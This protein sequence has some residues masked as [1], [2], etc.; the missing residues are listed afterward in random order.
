MTT[1]ECQPHVQCSRIL[2]TLYLPLVHQSYSMC[3]YCQKLYRLNF[4]LPW[5]VNEVRRIILQKLGGREVTQYNSNLG[6]EFKITITTT[7]KLLDTNIK[8]EST[9]FLPFIHIP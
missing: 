3:S 1:V 7:F 6:S 9:L 8:L 4:Y 5:K 2:G